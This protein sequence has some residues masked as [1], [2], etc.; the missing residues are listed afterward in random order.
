MFNSLIRKAITL[1]LILLSLVPHV[2]M[3]SVQ[4][5]IVLIETD[6][7]KGSGVFVKDDSK[8]Y[9]YT[10]VHVLEGAR[11]FSF[12]SISGDTYTPISL[13]I[14]DDVDLARM[15]LR[16][17][18]DHSL[19]IR[20]RRIA[21]GEFVYAY[22]DSLG[23][24]VVTRLEG[25][26]LGLGPTDVEVSAHIVSGNSGG[27]IIDSENM[28]IGISAF[29]VTRS[30]DAITDGTRFSGTRRFGLRL[31]REVDW[32]PV[33]VSDFVDVTGLLREDRQVDK[34][35][36]VMFKHYNTLDTIESAADLYRY[37]RRR[38]I[39]NIEWPDYDSVLA[40]EFGDERTA[41]IVRDWANSVKEF[42]HVRYVQ[43]PPL[44]EKDRRVVLL[45]SNSD[46]LFRDLIERRKEVLRSTYWP[47]QYLRDI[48]R[49]TYEHH[50]SVAKL[51]RD[52]GY[53][54]D[55]RAIAR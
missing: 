51:F 27:P 15:R 23:R 5:A 28:L 53:Y 10:C 30:P 39:E 55:G 13:E 6:I 1:P 42:K 35:Y 24:G 38:L 22:G 19:R 44:N 11:S 4:D 34:V 48:A 41:R 20:P 37:T 7:S 47:S 21:I 2:S 16:E 8:F 26:V 46:E 9:I 31:D 25:S 43:N 52:H 33:N 3:S 18:P 29:G 49:R 17:E 12:Q 14:A 45:L 32:K 40:L 50:Q 54:P 36:I